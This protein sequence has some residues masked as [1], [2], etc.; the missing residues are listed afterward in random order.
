LARTRGRPQ[1]QIGQAKDALHVYYYQFR[2]GGKAKPAEGGEGPNVRELFEELRTALR[3]KRYAYST[4]KS[5]TDKVRAFLAYRADIGLLN[6]PVVPE[7]VKNYLTHLAM[8]RQ[9]SKST[10]NSTFHALVFF[11]KHVL[12][13]DLED[14]GKSVRAKR[15][16]NLPAVVWPDEA[17][18][19]LSQLTGDEW[20][21]VAMLYGTG[22]RVSE[23]AR[24]RVKDLD[25][26][27]DCVLVRNGKGDKD[28]YTLLP[29][30]LVQPLQE[31]L[32]HVQA[33]HREDLALGLGEVYMPDALGRKYPA[34][35]REWGWQYVFPVASLAVDPRSG[36]SRRHHITPQT[37]QRAV[38]D[39]AGKAGFSKHVTPHTLR[40]GFAT[41]L[42]LNGADI[43]EVQ[44]FLGHK[45]LETTMVYTHVIRQRKGNVA[46]PLDVLGAPSG[47]TPSAP[48]SA[49]ARPGAGRGTEVGR[50]APDRQTDARPGAVRGTEV[51]RAA[52]DRQT[53]AR[54]GAVRGTEVGRMA[55]SRQDDARPEAGRDT[56]GRPEVYVTPVPPPCGTLGSQTPVACRSRASPVRSTSPAHC[57]AAW[58]ADAR[59][60]ASPG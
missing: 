25:F 4:E 2:N 1:W 17:E 34:A 5:Y 54:P 7:D 8:K 33:I 52:P 3:R 50:A 32:R 60:R 14:V 35:G 19:L 10:Q 22:L 21:W 42:L 6:R 44:E 46:S 45:S 30:S 47:S 57:Q 28:R 26:S 27:G 55:T 24:L 38:R 12:H 13:Q 53:D 36:I 16:R 31:H 29:A 11:F 39:A 43:R 49:P 40:H 58:R 41:A 59:I 20:L 48:A 51:G 23:L 15:G 18:R 56:T 9:I 37:V